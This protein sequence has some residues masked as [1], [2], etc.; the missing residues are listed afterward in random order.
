MARCGA[1]DFAGAHPA[2]KPWV[3]LSR[4]RTERGG[5]SLSETRTSRSDGQH[6]LPEMLV[7]A[8]MR[9]RR[10]G[11]GKREAAVD[12]QLEL[13]RGHCIPQI[14]AHAASNLAHLLEC[15]GAKGYTDIINAPQ[16][17]EIEIE[18]GLHAGEPADVDDA[19]ENR[20]RLHGLR[21]HRP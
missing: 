7:L 14:G 19:A 17:M 16:S 13:A 11:F 4:E 8:H 20:R 12:R 2:T 5:G 18:L 6:N 10:H 1:P 9:L 3:P 21:D 15:S